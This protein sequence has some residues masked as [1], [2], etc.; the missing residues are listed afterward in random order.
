MQ[1]QHRV[2]FRFEDVHIC[3][4]VGFAHKCRF[5]LSCASCESAFEIQ[6][7]EGQ[8]IME[9]SRH[10]VIVLPLGPIQAVFGETGFLMLLARRR[11][12]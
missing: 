8:R 10:R 6:G 2:L 3:Y 5:Q 4:I 12:S 9:T 7:A 11:R 1:R